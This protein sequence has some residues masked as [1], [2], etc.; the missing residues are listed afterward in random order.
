MKTAAAYSVNIF[1]AGDLAMIEQT[2]RNY[3]LKAFCV[4]VTPTNYIFTGGAEPG[5]IIGLIN[6][7]RFPSDNPPAGASILEARAMELAYLLM[8]Q[9][10]QRSCSVV[11]PTQSIYLENEAIAIPR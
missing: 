6:Y 2:C 9:C 5:A 1:I 10:C 3:C 4:T 7:A 8:T 11:T